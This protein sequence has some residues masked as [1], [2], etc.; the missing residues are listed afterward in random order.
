M[1]MDQNLQLNG[2]KIVIEYA[3]D[4]LKRQSE[5]DQATRWA[6]TSGAPLTN[7]V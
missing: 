5:Y 1:S 7:M 3:I 2:R 6:W 4:K